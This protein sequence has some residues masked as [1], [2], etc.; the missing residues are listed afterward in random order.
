MAEKKTIPKTD[1]SKKVVNER[2]YMI[3]LMKEWNKV[4]RYK[5][6]KKS[7]RAIRE[8]VAKHMKVYDRD[9]NKIKIDRFLNEEVWFRGI[10][11]PPKKIKVKAVKDSS[12]IV[13][14]ELVDYKDNLKFKKARE[15]RGSKSAEEKKKAK[16][17][18]KAP[19]V[20][21]EKKEEKKEQTAE[22]RKDEVEKE[23]AVEE[24]GIK[25]A[26]LEHKQH[27]HQAKEDFKQPK[28]LRRQA[29]QK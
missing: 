10:K 14:V 3:P 23:K 8:F 25:V 20:E 19:K 24:T 5:R 17:A 7:I 18:K 27:K 21:E 12:G 16:E 28:H 22:E 2:S 9:L 15:E 13:R 1:A 6:A 11:H 29:L 4:P 26:E